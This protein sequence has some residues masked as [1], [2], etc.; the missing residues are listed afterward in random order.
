MSTR[1][2]T[3]ILLSLLLNIMFIG[4][5]GNILFISLSKK[6]AFDQKLAE[7]GLSP[8]QQSALKAELDAILAQSENSR[9]DSKKQLQEVVDAL[10]A[11]SFNEWEYKQA[12]ERMDDSRRKA[13]RQMTR[14]LQAL[15]TKL[16]QPERVALSQMLQRSFRERHV[17]ALR[18]DALQ[19]PTSTAP[20][21]DAAPTAPPTDQPSQPLPPS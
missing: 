7:T 1:I 3:L 9:E 2:K 19:V 16:S 13:R 15:A 14:G 11:P 10:T 21:T 17:K 18:N 20:A 5:C 8:E 6:G 4:F 12:V